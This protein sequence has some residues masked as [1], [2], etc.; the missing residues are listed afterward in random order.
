MKEYKKEGMLNK[1][2]RKSEGRE[3]TVKVRKQ[4]VQSE[5]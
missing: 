5:K 4:T 3:M 2:R 1:E